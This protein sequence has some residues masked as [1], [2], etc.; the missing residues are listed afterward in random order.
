MDAD[1]IAAV[2]R[3]GLSGF[4]RSQLAGTELFAGVSQ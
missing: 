4:W 1:R 3:E 2:G